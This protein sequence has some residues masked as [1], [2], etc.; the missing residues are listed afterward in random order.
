MKNWLL[1]AALVALG[2]AGMAQAQSTKAGS[3]VEDGIR[4][5]VEQRLNAKP[6]TVT[7]MP[8]GLYEIVIGT[9]VFYV[10]SEV[11]YALVGGRAIDLKTRDDLTGK[12]RDELLRVDFKSLPLD[13]AMKI[14]R[15]DGSRK[16]V[17]F[18]DPNCG[19]CK[20]LYRDLSGLKNVT[21]YTFLYPILSQDSFEKSRGIWCA[22]DRPKTWEDWML[23][24]KAP[25]GASA[26]CK[27][28][29]QQNVE[30][31]RKLEV[32]G[33]PTIVFADGRRMPGAVPLDRI[34]AVFKE[35]G[36]K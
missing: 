23:N 4:A 12:K 14:V 25:P 35:I 24:G 34:E 3:P 8:F 26:E 22:K 18:E 15:G 27:H 10:D 9:E 16:L 31:G 5:R 28:P 11:N 6:D 30:L 2:A 21:I 13:Q 20:K 17:T 33:T 1:A 32:S 36:G 29:L 19:Y 7:R